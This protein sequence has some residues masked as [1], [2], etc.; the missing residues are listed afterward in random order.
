MRLQ[1]SL[2]V[3]LQGSV[4]NRRLF[5]AHETNL[6]FISG[7]TT[8]ASFAIPPTPPYPQSCERGHAGLDVPSTVL[9][10]IAGNLMTIV[11][12]CC[13]NTDVEE[14]PSQRAQ[15]SFHAVPW[16]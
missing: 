6:R 7:L 3:S 13:K 15:L 4:D 2:A 1:S 5:G 9:Y 11:N 12:L 16:R 14:S 8:H 10:R